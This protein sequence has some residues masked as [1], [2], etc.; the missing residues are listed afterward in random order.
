MSAALPPVRLPAV[1][2]VLAAPALRAAIGQHGLSQATASVRAVID[3]LRP[4]ALAGALGG[5]ALAPDLIAERAAA[6]LA[7]RAVPR[8]RSVFNL[9]GT[10]LHTNLGRA[11][12]PEAAVQS[13]VRALTTP[14]NLEFDLA[15]GGRGDRDDLVEDLLRELT[16][17]QAATVVNNNAAAVL[18]T[19]NALAARKEVIVSRG[20]LVEIG[21]AFRIPDIMARA[22]ARL[23]EVGTT[24]RT[25]PRDYEE[26][27]TDRTAL[28]MKVHCSNY[29]VTGFTKSVSVGEAAAIAHARGLPLAVD[30]GSGT[31]VEL[32]RW[33]LP[34]EA[35]VRETV[36]AGADLVTFSGDKL[37]GGP[38]AGLIVG[39]KDLIARIKKNPLKRALRVGKL[40]LAALEPVLR[41]YQA[42]E[43]LAER[44]TTLRLLTRPQAAMQA[45][46]ERLRA[47][48]Q[49]ALG[50]A[51]RL[52]AEPMFSQIGSGALPGGILPS[53]GLVARPAT[54]RRSGRSLAQ[55]EAALRALARPVLGRVASDALWLDLR[56]LEES[57]EAG[58]AAQFPQLGEAIAAP[59]A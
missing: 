11:L 35:T 21:G 55:L 26:A 34:H 22:G 19:L 25:H 30:L 31:L 13:V 29:A 32:T 18:L 16:G 12:L 57:D 33:G 51:W 45:Q 59:S 6:H 28:L 50:P 52:Q 10:V 20:E 27:I 39:R 1:D 53:H 5:A 15:S 9:T 4:Q 42:P 8:L 3:A 37:L 23:V 36:E 56:C 41:L 17:A 49:A 48:L 54:A 2:R 38:Q 24:N 47:P 58:F 7:A 44:L 14:A 46:A 43:F 40:T